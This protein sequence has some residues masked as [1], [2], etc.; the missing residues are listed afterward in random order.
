MVFKGVAPLVWAS[1]SDTFGTRRKIYLVSFTIFIITSA[2]GGFSSSIWMLMV[3][4]GL[5]SCGSS[6]VQSIGAGTISDIFAAY[7]KYD[8]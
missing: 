2:L 1:Y 6:A 8:Y 7:G 5:Q 4:R 3:L